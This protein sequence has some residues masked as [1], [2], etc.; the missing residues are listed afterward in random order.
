MR[1]L[2]PTIRGWHTKFYNET[3]VAFQFETLADCEQYL[4]VLKAFLEE[5]QELRRAGFD[6]VEALHSLHADYAWLRSF[7]RRAISSFR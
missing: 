2:L 5:F 6:W 4:F 3:G 1:E 7:E